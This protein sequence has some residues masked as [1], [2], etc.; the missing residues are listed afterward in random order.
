MLSRFLFR[1]EGI[2]FQKKDAGRQRAGSPGRKPPPQ[3]V[4]PV[5][6]P[7]RSQARL[8]F[9]D[10]TW[11]KT[12]MTRHA[13]PGRRAVS[14]SLPRSHTV[15]GRPRRFLAALRHDGIEA[16]CLFRRA[17]QWA[18]GFLGLRQA[19]ARPYPQARRYC[20]PRQPRFPQGQDGAPG[21]SKGRRQADLPAQVL[22][23]T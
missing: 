5:S 19:D 16:P 6:G 12:N 1:R 3:S 15:I 2:T 17:D 23:P 20:H 9:I 10:E 21:H 8:V 22:P 13:R 18:R 7:D 4:A 11:A 14:G